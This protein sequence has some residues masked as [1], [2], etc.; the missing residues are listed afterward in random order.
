MFSP[1]THASYRKFPR[2]VSAALMAL[3]LYQQIP[4]FSPASVSA[5]LEE[6]VRSIQ[7][8]DAEE[9]RSI[10]IL[11]KETSEHTAMLALKQEAAALYPAPTGR[12]P[13][14]ALIAH[15]EKQVGLNDQGFRDLTGVM[16]ETALT[17]AEWAKWIFR[18]LQ[19]G[20]ATKEVLKKKTGKTSA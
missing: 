7:N 3:D 11:L 6:A 10:R 2:T 19:A 4:I 16:N 8:S 14:S 18:D 15:P 5:F 9:K 1:S 17:D 12:C 20:R 13:I